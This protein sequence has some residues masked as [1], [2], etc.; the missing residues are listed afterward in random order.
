MTD[1][2][3]CLLPD[4]IFLNGP[5]SS[6]KTTLARQLQG[7]LSQPYLYLGIDKII[8]MMPPALNDW[9]GGKAT[10]GF[11]WEFTKDAQGFPL[12]HIQ[13]GPFAHA[14]ASFLKQVVVL[15]L[16][17][18][19]RMIVDEVCVVADSFKAWKEVLRPWRVFYVG[20]KASTEILENREKARGDRTPGS[21]RAQNKIVHKQAL[22]D[23]ELDM[24]VLSPEA[25]VTKV[26]EAVS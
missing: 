10:Q 4:V 18:G 26:M 21:A 9:T 11:W 23:L 5:S 8:E 1:N 7:T 14:M 24:D 13:L 3:F 15:A 22:Y 25:C 12:A 20:L 6:G 2:R 19:H 17:N 16:N